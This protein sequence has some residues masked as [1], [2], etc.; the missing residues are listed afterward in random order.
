M[1]SRNPNDQSHRTVWVGLGLVL[2]TFLVYARVLNCG[3]IDY[4]DPDYV[5]DNPQ[6]KTA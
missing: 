1:T 5:T 2:V 4:D 3:F 6:V